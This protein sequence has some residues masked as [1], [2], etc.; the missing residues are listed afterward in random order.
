MQVNFNSYRATSP[1]FGM[2][3][4]TEKGREVVTKTLGSVPT[5][6]SDVIYTK[7]D[8]LAK[9]L[10]KFKKS[11]VSPDEIRDVFQAGMTDSSFQNKMF[12]KKQL[13]TRNGQ[14]AI[15]SF[16]KAQSKAAGD[17]GNT[18]VGNALIDSVVGFFDRN[19]SNEMISAKEGKM[20]LDTVKTQADASKVSERLSIVTDKMFSK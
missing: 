14:G 16:L 13:L 12:A 2:A 19:I 1:S 5:F 8:V 17:T 7:K 6:E 20:I 15:K 11:P 4:L 10:K 9:M 3:K 18:E